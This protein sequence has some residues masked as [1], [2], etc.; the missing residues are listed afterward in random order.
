MKC[1]FVLGLAVA[2][3]FLSISASAQATNLTGTCGMVIKTSG[4]YVLQ[5]NI[6]NCNPNYAVPSQIAAITIQAD[7]VVLDLNG[8]TIS[9]A[10]G[11]GISIYGAKN[12]TIKNGTIEKFTS[13]Q[14]IVILSDQALAR[15]PSDIIIEKM[16][17]QKNVRAIY[18]NR[19]GT[20]ERLTIRDSYFTGNT[21]GGAIVLFNGKGG[22]IYNNDI[23]AN[24]KFGISLDNTIYFQ[25]YQNSI[26]KQ[27]N[28]AVHLTNHADQNHIYL[29]GICYNYYGILIYSGSRNMFEGNSIIKNSK[30]ATDYDSTNVW[31]NNYWSD[32][33]CANPYVIPGGGGQQDPTPL[34]QPKEEAA[35]CGCGVGTVCGYKWNDLNA[36]GKW[37]A[38]EIGLGGWQI[39][40][41][42]PADPTFV[43]LSTTT[44]RD[45]SYCFFGLK[46]GLYT[47]SEAQQEGWTQTY[48][49]PPGTYSGYLHDSEA[50]YGISFGNTYWCPNPSIIM[51]KIGPAI[52]NAGDDLPFFYK[53]TNNGN[54]P[55]TNIAV[56]DDKCGNATYQSG[57]GGGA[58]LEP[59]ET[60]IYSCTY[61]PSFPSQFPDCLTNVAT[62]TGN[63]NSQQVKA[64]DDYTV[65]PFVLRKKIFLYW[66]HQEATIPYTGTDNTAFT[67]KVYKDGTELGETIISQEAE[68]QFWLSQGTWK[69]C[70]VNVPAGYIPGYDCITFKTGEGYPDWTY[71]N[72]I[73]YDLAVDKTCP[74]TAKPGETIT[75]E[76]KV[77][78]A[79]PASVPAV[80]TDDKCSSVVYNSGDA[81]GNLKV[82]LGEI[83]TFT[84]QY[85]TPAGAASITNTATVKDPNLPTASWFLGGDRNLSNNTDTCTVTIG[86]TGVYVPGEFCTYTQGGWGAK[87]AGNNVGDLLYDNFAFVYPLHQVEVGIGGAQGYSM[88]FTDAIVVKDFMAMTEYL[89]SG[90][91]AGAL[92]HDYTNPTGDNESGVFGG[93]VTALQL[94]VDFA[95]AGKMPQ[96]GSTPVGALKICNAGTYFDGKTVS[97]VLAVANTALGGGALPPGFDL[98]TLNTYGDLLNKAFDNCVPSDWA[99]TN[100]C[101]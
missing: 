17:I 28:A 71:P 80:V 39:K 88:I 73:T 55:L 8:R 50:V 98:P 29:N 38:G 69:F 100:L 15:D 31:Q 22:A 48:P 11:S 42:S 89:P 95:K 54:V 26:S 84:C 41:E 35:P 36:D 87:P 49:P 76:Y 74:G 63:Y 16:T 19:T 53:V 57:N 25:I 68:R 90:G 3:L 40:L 97:Q 7:N 51:E 96:T 32:H 18:G 52:G 61:K 13:G 43:P 78:N 83:W 47:V 56:S 81:N 10:G 46:P 66:D 94:N 33:D 92:A 21:S 44:A 75:Y 82:D 77:T 34:C 2:L 5:N 20:V 37:T 24:G 14:G 86:G 1:K 99:Q 30:P 91:T 58:A 64:T 45:G 101:R 12:V 60:W 62:A 6:A 93:Q 27:T 79:G 67:V 72:A 70:E 23:C 9:G 4:N 59:G 85:V 65:C